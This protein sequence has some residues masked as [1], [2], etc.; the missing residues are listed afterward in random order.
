MRTLILL[1]VAC[2][3]LFDGVYA[4][5]NVPV[6]DQQDTLIHVG[7]MTD[8]SSAEI[9]DAEDQEWTSVSAGQR[10][11][12]NSADATDRF[13]EIPFMTPDQVVQFS[14]YKSQCGPFLHPHEL[15]AIPGW[16]AALVRMLLPYVVVKQTTILLADRKRLYKSIRIQM[17]GVADI[18][19]SHSDTA[20]RFIDI[21]SIRKR[22]LLQSAVGIKAGIVL[23]KDR[24][25]EWLNQKS[26]MP[27]HVGYFI[28]RRTST[29]VWVVG[30]Y[31][32][33]LGNGLLKNQHMVGLLSLFRDFTATRNPVI[34]PHVSSNE[35]QYDRG[36][37]F[38]LKKKTWTVGLYASRKKVDGRL[39]SDIDPVVLSWN[40]TGLHRSAMERMTNNCVFVQEWG[41]QIGYQLKNTQFSLHGLRTQWRQPFLLHET[42]N[43]FSRPREV[44]LA[45]GIGVSV[46]VSRQNY[47]ITTELA[48][49][50]THGL[51]FSA[52]L[53]VALA[54]SVDM[55]IELSHIGKR[56]QSINNQLHEPVEQASNRRFFNAVLRYTPSSQFSVTIRSRRVDQSHFHSGSDRQ[57]VM[58]DIKIKHKALKPTLQFSWV[59]HYKWSMATNPID[60]RLDE[61]THNKLVVRLLSPPSALTSW[62][63]SVIS[64]WQQPNSCEKTSA[65]LLSGRLRLILRKSSLKTGLY[66]YH[67]DG[68][69]SRMIIPINTITKS[70]TVESVYNSGFLCYLSLQKRFNQRFESSIQTIYKHQAD[71]SQHQQMIRVIFSLK[72]SLDFSKEEG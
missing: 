24:G 70:Q 12:L 72:L 33:K 66:L 15:Q 3:W 59:S 48:L 10:I 29:M 43:R 37:G 57:D 64:Q 23:E 31:R 69:E 34:L 4:Q 51:A 18:K 56:Y 65:L 21:A 30:D 41:A 39:S 67:T 35:W 17:E 50:P 55:S 60:H 2:I 68:Y 38:Q 28:E 9:S 22:Y 46:A 40:R 32:V 54:K 1:G 25:E 42:Q 27:D 20:F 44:R 7:V 53:L 47:F 26:G 13:S 36:I 52:G 71:I 62:D 8:V 49:R 16:D 58:A 19:R 5:V 11:D 6:S 14:V 61:V 63:I 45:H